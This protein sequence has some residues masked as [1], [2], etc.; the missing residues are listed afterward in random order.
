MFSNWC[1]NDALIWKLMYQKHKQSIFV[2][3]NE[4]KNLY[5]FITFHN[6]YTFCIAFD[7]ISCHIN[8]FH[9]TLL[10]MK[11]HWSRENIRYR[12]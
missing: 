3:L 8:I 1:Q 5:I 11:R 4:K 7:N 9:D 12:T 10:K 6:Q 2:E